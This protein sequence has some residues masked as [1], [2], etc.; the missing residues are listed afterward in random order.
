MKSKKCKGCSGR[1]FSY[2]KLGY[3]MN[4]VKVT[5]DKCYGKGFR[6]R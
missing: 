1:G 3:G 6:W 5:C 4:K 2:K